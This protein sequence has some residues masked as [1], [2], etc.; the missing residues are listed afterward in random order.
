MERGIPINGWT[1]P[2]H[3]DPY[4]DCGNTLVKGCPNVEDHHQA[5]LDKDVIGKVFVLMKRR[6]CMRPSCPVCYEKWAARAAHRIEA[7]IEQYTGSGKP[8]H[9]MGSVPHDLYHLSMVELRTRSQRLVRKV[10]L[11]GGSCIV[12]PYREHC[13]YCHEPKDTQIK[14]CPKCGCKDFSWYFSPHFHFIGYGWIQGKKVAHVYHKTGWVIKNLG[15]RDSV[16]RTAQYQ[17]SHAGIHPNHDTVTWFGSMS[18]RKMKT[19]PE[20]IELD[21]CPLCGAELVPL[22]WVGHGEMPFTKEGEYYDKADNWI[23]DTS[24]RGFGN[25]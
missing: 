20:E 8:I 22:I 5:C 6:S 2:G 14:R 4:A 10:G 12:H 16:F 19:I 13:V 23:R 24:F 3:G 18:R 15:I 21:T 1:L 17:L 9:V 25:K 7:R 11:F